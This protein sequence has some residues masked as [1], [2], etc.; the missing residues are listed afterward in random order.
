MVLL[1]SSFTITPRPTPTFAFPFDSAKALFAVKST[2]F[3]WTFALPVALTV[4]LV[5]LALVLFDVLFQTKAPPA[6]TKEFPVAS[7]S[8]FPLIL[9][10]KLLFKYVVWNAFNFLFVF[11]NIV[12]GDFTLS[13]WIFPDAEFLTEFKL[14]AITSTFSVTSTLLSL[15][16][17][18]LTLF[19][20]RFKIP[21]KDK[22]ELG[23]SPWCLTSLSI[24][25]VIASLTSLSE[26]FTAPTSKFLALTFVWLS[27][28][29]VVV[30][31]VLFNKIANAPSSTGIDNKLSDDITILFLFKDKA[32]TFVSL[33]EFKTESCTIALDTVLVPTP[34]IPI[35]I[36]WAKRFDVAVKDE[37]A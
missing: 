26:R 24:F 14:C 7:I 18:A 31:V 16:I 2:V 11:V 36:I 5:I 17:S 34:Y 37:S 8:V 27:F 22:A 35:G 13:S 21:T 28:A 30:F 1:C 6:L 12:S 15:L 32:P 23:V 20:E 25:A 19:W 9:E 4:E 33:V 29:S 3:A 10:N